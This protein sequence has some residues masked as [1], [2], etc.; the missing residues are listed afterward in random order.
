MSLSAI[1]GVDEVMA[2]Y[3]AKDRRTARKVMHEAGGFSVA[4]KLV[5]REDDLGR[6]EQRQATARRV[7]NPSPVDLPK[8]ARNAAVPSPATG[9]DWWRVDVA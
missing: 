5:V 8:R 9:A 1:L 3:G 4:G 2:R 6:W 7:T